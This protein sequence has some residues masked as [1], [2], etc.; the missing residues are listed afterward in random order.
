MKHLKLF[1]TIAALML[2]A[3]ILFAWHLNYKPKY[4]LFPAIPEVTDIPMEAAQLLSSLPTNMT[5]EKLSEDNIL[6]LYRATPKEERKPPLPPPPDNIDDLIRLRGIVMIGERRGALIELQGAAAQ[7]TVPA[8]AGKTGTK[9]KNAINAGPETSATGH[10]TPSRYCEEGKTITLPKGDAVLT[11]VYADSIVINYLLKDFTLNLR[12]DWKALNSEMEK[13]KKAAEPP[14]PAEPERR[15]FN[16][17]QPPNPA[18][19][20]KHQ[21][22]RERFEAFMKTER[23]RESKEPRK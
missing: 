10:F 20:K 19:M 9:Q 12:Y 2:V 13:F 7:V 21:E 23:E 8:A 15:G 3:V 18:E 16:R 5:L 14:P 4:T 1:G 11:Q 22:R 17:G 6:S